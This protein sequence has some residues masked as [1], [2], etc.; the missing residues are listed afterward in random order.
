MGS[1]KY[2]IVCGCYLESHA[3]L[4]VGCLTK[5]AMDKDSE[6]EFVKHVLL[7]KHENSVSLEVTSQSRN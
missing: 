2:K 3:S 1:S 4:R 5:D 7:M 6:Q